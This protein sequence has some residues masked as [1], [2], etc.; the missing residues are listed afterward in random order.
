MAEAPEPAAESPCVI[1]HGSAIAPAAFA[2]PAHDGIQWRPVGELFARRGG[3]DAAVL[4]AD[5]SML[6]PTRVLR[7]VPSHIVI[8]AADIASESALGRRAHFSVAEFRDAASRGRVLRA[9]CQLSCARLTAM[10][11]RRQLARTNRELRELS[12]IGMALTEERDRDTLLRN[13]LVLGK[14]LTTSDG[15]AIFLVDAGNG[16]PPVLRSA[17]HDFNSLPAI[18]VPPITFPIDD[19]SIVGHAALIKKPVVIDDAYE[20]PADADY[21]RNAAF[22]ER[23]GYRLRSMLIVP[24]VD[25]HARMVGVL[26]LVNRVSDPTA[27]ITSMAAA[28]R[29]VLPYTR[30]EVRLAR[31]LAGQAAVSIENARLYAQIE[32]IFESF[33]KAAVTAIDDRD[34][35]TSGHSIRVAELTVAL[36]NAVQRDGRGAFRDLRFTRPQIRELR[37]AALLHDFG[38]LSV[39]ED[40]LVKAKKLP[41]VLWERINGRFDLIRCGM[42]S[43]PSGS[44]CGCRHV[45]IGPSTTARPSS[46]TT[47]RSSSACARPFAT[48]TNPA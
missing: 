42:N 40:V 31:S 3:T 6:Q 2:Q 44:A 15:G 13:I 1:Y 25:H 45:T 7:N 26:V 24:M 9:A 12:H 34:P 38:K 28:D 29:Y 10:R 41:P 8:I 23:Y 18:E 36:A 35:A 19:T 14:Q 27:R 4:I 20:L 30:R 37:Y 47:S 22:D 16:T 5:S 21:T 48:R 17:V 32:H 43:S 46:P 39:H 33:V 11:R